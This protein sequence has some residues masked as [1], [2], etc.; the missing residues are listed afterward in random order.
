MFLC[1][2]TLSLPLVFS[3][4]VFSTRSANEVFDRY[5]DNSDSFMGGI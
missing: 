1:Y 3:F 2:Y 5:L 4:F